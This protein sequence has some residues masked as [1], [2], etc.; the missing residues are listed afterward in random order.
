MVMCYTISPVKA[1]DRN[2]RYTIMYVK[3]YC[4]QGGQWVPLHVVEMTKRQLKIQKDKNA[5]RLHLV[6]S[7]QEAHRWVRNGGI[8]G[9]ALYVDSDKRIRRAGE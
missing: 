8:H 9:T 1:L 6:I 4:R 3:V 5:Y 7:G 2:R